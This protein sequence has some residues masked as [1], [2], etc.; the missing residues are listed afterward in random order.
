MEKSSKDLVVKG[1]QKKFDTAEQVKAA[2][3]AA[4]G[5]KV[6]LQDVTKI[7]IGGNSYGL[8]ACRWVAE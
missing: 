7:T 1:E 6:A 2:F 4:C 5:G 8:E 3:E